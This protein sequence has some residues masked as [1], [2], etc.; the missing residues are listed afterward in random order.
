MRFFNLLVPKSCEIVSLCHHK[1]THVQ[2]S[3]YFWVVMKR[4]LTFQLNAWAE[5][6]LRK[7]LIV[8]GARQV[9]K[10]FLLREFGRLKFNQVHEFN[11]QSTPTLSSIFGSKTSAFE[12][13]TLTRL[14]Q[15]DSIASNFSD[16]R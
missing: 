16:N 7:P 1:M 6:A 3:V 11:F 13:V 10:T 15:S 8:L 14:N 5:G 2:K 9:G 4:S 12:K